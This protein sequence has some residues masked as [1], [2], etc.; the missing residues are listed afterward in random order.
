MGKLVATDLG[1]EVIVVLAGENILER[2]NMRLIA[3]FVF[4]K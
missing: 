4:K 3:G 1:S 2:N